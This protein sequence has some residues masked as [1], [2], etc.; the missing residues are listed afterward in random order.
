MARKPARDRTEQEEWAFKDRVL[1]GMSPEEAAQIKD[2]PTEDGGPVREP[3]DEPFVRDPAL[4]E[5][6]RTVY[7]GEPEDKK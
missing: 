3:A 6:D 1:R 7:S 2:L 4:V 5:A